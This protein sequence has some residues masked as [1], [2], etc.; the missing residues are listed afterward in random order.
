MGKSTTDVTVE[1]LKEI[2]DAVRETNVRVDQTNQRLDQTNQRLDLVEKTL[3]D[4]AAQFLFI[5]RYIGNTVDHQTGRI[6]A[7]ETRVGKIEE[8]IGSG[9]G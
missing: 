3:A 2:R 7:L 4:M 6:D 5:S 1:I 9:R 8:R